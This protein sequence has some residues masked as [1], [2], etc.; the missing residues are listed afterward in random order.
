MSTYYQP[1]PEPWELMR[2]TALCLAVWFKCRIVFTIEMQDGSK[3]TE[4][5]DRLRAALKGGE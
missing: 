1:P 4:E 2:T 3:I 5:I